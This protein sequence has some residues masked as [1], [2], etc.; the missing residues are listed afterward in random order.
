MD[1]VS[2]GT[3]NSIILDVQPQIAGAVHAKYRLRVEGRMGRGGIDFEHEH[4]LEFSPK[5]LSVFISTNKVVYNGG[6]IA[7]IRAVFL[8]TSM[9]PYNGIV[10]LFVLDPEGYIMRKWDSKELNVGVLS[11]DLEIPLLPKVGFW[12]IRV[13]AEGQVEEATIKVT[14]L[15][16]ITLSLV[17]RP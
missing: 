2:P 7:R 15:Y 3:T 5:F 9:K 12:T 6:H 1:S 17:H 14:I 16:K 4:E 11:Q 10:R 8:T 13:V